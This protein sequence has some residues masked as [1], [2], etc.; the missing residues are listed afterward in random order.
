MPRLSQARTLRIPGYHPRV[1][2]RICTI[3][4][5]VTLGQAGAAEP[6]RQPLSYDAAAAQTAVVKRYEIEAGDV[7]RHVLRLLDVRRVFRRRPPVFDGVA[8]TEMRERGTADLVDQSG[9]E[10][11]YVTYLLE[12]GNRVFGRYSGT[13]RSARWPDGSWH[14]EVQGRIEL[15]GGTGRFERLRGQVQVGYVL[16]PGAESSQGESAG[17]YWFER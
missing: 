7:P 1:L 14:H 9:T 5:A 3:V 6:A 12:D 4:L 8:A 10:S 2:W 15:T 11:A 17:E 13:L 16:D